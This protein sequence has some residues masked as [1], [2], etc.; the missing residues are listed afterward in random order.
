LGIERF[1]EEKLLNENVD[2][3]WWNL[4]FQYIDIVIPSKEEEIDSSP[5]QDRT[6]KPD[7]KISENQPSLWEDQK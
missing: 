5:H 4:A 1:F 3:N 7:K 2:M 6:I